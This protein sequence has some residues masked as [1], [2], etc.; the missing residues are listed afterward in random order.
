MRS[1]SLLRSLTVHGTVATRR[2]LDLRPPAKHTMETYLLVELSY[3]VLGTVLERGH[4]CLLRLFERSSQRAVWMTMERGMRMA[5]GRAGKLRPE[6]SRVTWLHDVFGKTM[7]VSSSL[8]CSYIITRSTYISNPQPF[9]LVVVRTYLQWWY[10]RF[11]AA[12]N[13]FLTLNPL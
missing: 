7:L 5:T 6:A 2:G 13:D 11:H 9:S 8:T 4:F 1:R 3:G 10:L 12:N